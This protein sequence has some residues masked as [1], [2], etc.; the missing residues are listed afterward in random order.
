MYAIVE[1][2]GKQFKVRRDGRVRVPSLVGEPGERVTFERVLCA[3][4]GSNLRIGAPTLEGV[5]VVGEIV[6]HGRAKKIVIFKFKKRHRYRKKQGHRQDF[7]EVAITELALDRNGEGRPAVE[8]EIGT[9]VERE[10][11][12]VGPYVCEECGRG[13]ATERGLQQ[14]RAKAH[15]GGESGS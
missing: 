1:S 7:T 4:D 12:Q 2:G 11:R 9:G 5:R 13:F 6:R 3:S 15:T 14:H 8:E 10:S